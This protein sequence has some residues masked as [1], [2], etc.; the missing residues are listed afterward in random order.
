ML[1]FNLLGE[2]LLRASE[3]QVR[4]TSN[5]LYFL[6]TRDNLHARRFYERR[7]YRQVGDLPGLIHPVFR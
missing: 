2:R 1:G 6:V 3:D 7:G 5:Y 4:A